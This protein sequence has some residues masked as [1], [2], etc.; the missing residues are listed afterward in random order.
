MNTSKQN[1]ESEDYTRFVMRWLYC[2]MAILHKVAILYEA[3]MLYKA[4]ILHKVVILHSERNMSR[5]V[6][7]RASSWT[8]HTAGRTVP[9]P[10]CTNSSKSTCP[11]ESGHNYIGLE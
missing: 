6:T 11:A 8:S 2:Q 9:T 3:A 10:P 1:P 4:A 7:T 5:V